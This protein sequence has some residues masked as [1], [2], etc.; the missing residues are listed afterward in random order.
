MQNLF[1][2]ISF[3][4]SSIVWVVLLINQIILHI[5]IKFHKNAIYTDKKKYIYK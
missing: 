3:L 5:L 1:W 4:D 2:Q